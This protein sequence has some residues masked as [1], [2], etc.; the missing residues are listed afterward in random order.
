MSL[1]KL[2]TSPFSFEKTYKECEQIQV[3]CANGIQ[4][5]LMLRANKGKVPD[6]MLNEMLD[7]VHPTYKIWLK[8]YLINQ[9]N[10]K[11]I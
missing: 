3:N 4:A 9:K 10:R 11:N 8:E 5:Y 7:K 6:K 2:S 1:D